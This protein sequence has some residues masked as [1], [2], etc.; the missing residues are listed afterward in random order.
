MITVLVVDDH[1]L[2]RTGI[3]RMLEDHA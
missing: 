3:C 2:V 1:E